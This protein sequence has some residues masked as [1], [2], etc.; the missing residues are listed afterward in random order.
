M[1]RLVLN[2][3]AVGASERDLVE[4]LSNDSSKARTL[5]PLIAALRQR[6]GEAVREPAEVLGVAADI[7]GRIEEKA[8]RGVLT[9]F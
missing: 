5:S 2:M 1:I 8:A 4:V 3:I 7:R 6:C 9:A